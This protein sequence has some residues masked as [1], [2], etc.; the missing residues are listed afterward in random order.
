MLSDVKVLKLERLSMNWLFII[1]GITATAAAVTALSLWLLKLS[2][3]QYHT[4]DIMGLFMSIV[5]VGS[6]FYGGFSFVS[7]VTIETDEH[8]I[9]FHEKPVLRFSLLKTKSFVVPW[10]EVAAWQKSEHNNLPNVMLDLGQH[11]QLELWSGTPEADSNPIDQTDI[12][13]ILNQWLP[14]KIETENAR[15][16][17]KEN[18]FNKSRATSNSMNAGCV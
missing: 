17:A 7:K 14:R 10:S 13:V 6:A 9:K 8:F 5:I 4:G 16:Q 12:F 1:F 3:Y 11:G 2:S 18:I 15:E